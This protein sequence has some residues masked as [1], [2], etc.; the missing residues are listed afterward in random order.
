MIKKIIILIAVTGLIYASDSG[1]IYRK[2]PKALSTQPNTPPQN[3]N[4]IQSARYDELGV[5]KWITMG[6]PNYQKSINQLNILLTLQR[7]YNREHK[8]NSLIHQ[9]QSVADEMH[10]ENYQRESEIIRHLL[11]ISALILRDRLKLKYDD[12]SIFTW[13]NWDEDN[14]MTR[15]LNNSLNKLKIPDKMKPILR[16]LMKTAENQKVY[17]IGITKNEGFANMTNPTIIK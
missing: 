8:R 17:K 9:I 5:P 15:A 12:D 7:D 6:G 10:N 16:N 1:R 3:S 14:N 2:R 4:H 11:I 13:V